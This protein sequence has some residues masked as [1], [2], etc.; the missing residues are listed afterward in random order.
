MR[1]AD[2]RYENST[3]WESL[4]PVWVEARE[5]SLRPD[6]TVL[7]EASPGEGKRV[8]VVVVSRVGAGNVIVFAASGLWR[9]KMAGPSE[10]DVFDALLANATRWLTARG[11]LSRVSAE[12]DKDVYAAGEK[13][14]VSAQV[15]QSDYRLAR[16]A[17]VTVDISTGQMA[18]PVESIVLSPDGDFYRGEAGPLPPGRYV[19]LAEGTAGDETI[20]TDSGEFV[21]EEFSLEDAEVRRRS[22]ILRRLAEESGGDYLS[23][24]TIDDLPESVPL[25]RRAVSVRRELELGTSPWP[26]IAIVGLL[27]SEWAIRRSKGMP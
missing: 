22:G 7:A 24:E 4:P 13:V 15:Y 18:A 9:W 26:P 19:V 17:S 5:W 27:A 8:P 25:E 20:G 10:P 3:L 1:V 2:G 16:D 23:P 21:V 11:E 6:A 12:T 14:R